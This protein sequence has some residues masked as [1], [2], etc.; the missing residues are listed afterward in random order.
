MVYWF[1][2]FWLLFDFCF[3]AHLRACVIVMVSLPG[4]NIVS[5]LPK[6]T[7][8]HMKDVNTSTARTR[9]REDS[10]CFAALHHPSARSLYTIS[11]LSLSRVAECLLSLLCQ[12]MI[13]PFKIK[14][15]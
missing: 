3:V 6:K 11:L 2:V 4:F 10:I 15:L 8:N 1:L 9:I 7:L 14:A 12:L 5:N 13:M